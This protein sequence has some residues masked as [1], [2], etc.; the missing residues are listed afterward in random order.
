MDA[1]TSGDPAAV[2]GCRRCEVL[3]AAERAQRR[4][5]RRWAWLE[6]WPGT[7]AGWAFCALAL[8]AIWAFGLAGWVGTMAAIVV[9][10]WLLEGPPR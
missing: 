8:A 3:A 6:S 7:L 5:D 10:L 9:A 4:R 2:V 1:A